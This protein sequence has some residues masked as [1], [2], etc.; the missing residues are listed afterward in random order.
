MTI[1]HFIVL[2]L[3]SFYSN[4]FYT[5]IAGESTY[6]FLNISSSPRNLAL[7]GGLLSEHNDEWEFIICLSCTETII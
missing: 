7:G 6:Q 4:K 2:T 5:Q 1:K 3:I